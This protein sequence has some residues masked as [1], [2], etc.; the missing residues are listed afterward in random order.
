MGYKIVSAAAEAI[1]I[2]YTFGLHSLRKTFGYQ[3]IKKGGKTLTLMKMYNH[4]SPDVTLRYVCWGKEDA[5]H[6]REAMYIG[7]KGMNRKR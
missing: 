2:P 5:E 1:G 7:P 6:D 4:A 3:Y